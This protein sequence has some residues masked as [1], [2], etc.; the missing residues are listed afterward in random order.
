MTINYF[1]PIGFPR[2]PITG[3]TPFT[4]RNGLT[5]LELLEAMREWI[6]TIMI[7]DMNDNI[8]KLL[9]NYKDAIDE[10]VKNNNA[11]IDQMNQ[12]YAEFTEALT[13]EML[14]FTTAVDADIAAHKDAVET[15]ITE[16]KASTTAEIAESKVYFDEVVNVINN[17]SG[18][19]DVQH[20]EL[21]E[22]YA[23]N[24]P[25]SWPSNLPAVFR[26]VQDSVGGHK[27]TAGSNVSSIPL[28]INLTPGSVSIMTF[29]PDGAGEFFGVLDNPADPV[30]NALDYGARGDGITDD[31]VALQAAADAARGFTVSEVSFG[32]ERTLRIPHGTYRISDTII[33]K[34]SL[35]AKDATVEFVYVAQSG[36]AAIQIGDKSVLNRPLARRIFDL[37]RIHCKKFISVEEVFGETN[38]TWVA[39]SVGVEL[40][41][42][43]TC[44]VTYQF[45]RG[46]A[47]GMLVHGYG[48]G[49][50]HN[51]F[52]QGSLWSNKV[53]L[54]VR[55]S[56]GTGYVTQNLF[57]NGRYSH[58]N[59]GDPAFKEQPDMHML[60]STSHE[61]TG[62]GAGNNVWHNTSWEGENIAQYR[63]K[64]DGRYNSFYNC[65]WEAPAAQPPRVFWGTNANFNKIVDGYNS[66]SI[67][68]VVET[69][70]SSPSNV[71]QTP[72]TFNVFSPQASPTHLEQA[73]GTAWAPIRWNTVNGNGGKFTYDAETG[74]ITLNRAGRWLI[75]ATVAFNANTAGRRG[76]RI[77]KGATTLDITETPGHDVSRY[78]TL[79]LFAVEG[80]QHGQTF[81]IDC[82]Q[83][84][85]DVLSLVATSGYNRFSATYLGIS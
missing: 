11:T 77:Q 49:V 68:E 46:F 28:R 61:A 63:L 22:D 27:L 80:F 51:T 34:S 59:G 17:K 69:P 55:A 56:G 36:R 81:S 31:T 38:N 54:H 44:I 1:M 14:E 64:V 39:G 53:N 16:Y 60:L 45:I 41:N 85:G 26:F 19:I 62:G 35:E 10:M 76:A 65:R 47:T 20:V 67:V 58:G 73:S 84:S 70:S 13:L 83:N 7:P 48:G 78:N 79:K 5:F 66:Q 29:M 8:D 33:V 25:E 42:I 75:T 21:T 37:P 43:N 74:L 24:I 32:S 40:L 2:F 12:L 3:I 57:L 4:Y 71:L 72:V 50:S 30:V 6:N 52:N 9:Q 15:D 23:V 82:L 18:M